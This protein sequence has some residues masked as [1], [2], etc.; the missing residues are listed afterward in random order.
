[1]FSILNHFP[2]TSNEQKKTLSFFPLPRHPITR[3][4]SLSQS[5]N[6][7]KAQPR[8][9]CIYF[10]FALLRVALVTA[11][12]E[13][14]EKK[15]CVDINCKIFMTGNSRSGEVGLTR[16]E[17]CKMPTSLLLRTI[18]AVGV[19]WNNV[20]LN[21]FCINTFEWKYLGMSS[22]IG[23]VF[24]GVGFGCFATRRKL[25]SRSKSNLRTFP[26]RG[27]HRFFRISSRFAPSERRKI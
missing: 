19:W 25:D 21:F 6:S 10:L 2:G 24:R 14:R 27:C 5:K 18:V 7:L 1:M 22:G 9:W 15:N 16:K 11:V 12:M 17:C 20:E 4:L 8:M 23:K 13:A 3:L 26:A